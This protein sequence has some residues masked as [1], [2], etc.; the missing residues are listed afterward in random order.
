MILGVGDDD[1]LRGGSVSIRFQLRRRQRGRLFRRRGNQLPF[2]WRLR[3][4]L[5]K[6]RRLGCNFAIAFNRVE[7]YGVRR[8]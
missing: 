4:A 7:I 2:W 5:P 3:R 8:G 6:R 1:D